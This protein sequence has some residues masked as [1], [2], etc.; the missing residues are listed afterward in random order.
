M[1][2]SRSSKTGAVIAV[3]V[4]L[5]LSVPLLCICGSS[6]DSAASVSTE[7]VSGVD[8]RVFDQNS[9]NYNALVY[10]SDKL[11]TSLSASEWV[12]DA[13][14]GHWYNINSASS[15][16][17]KVLTYG[18]IPG[19]TKSMIKGDILASYHHCFTSNFMLIQVGYTLKYDCNVQLEIVKGNASYTGGSDALSVEASGCYFNK[20]VQKYS[21]CSVKDTGSD[22]DLTVADYRGKY[23][24][25]IGYNGIPVDSVEYTYL[26][27]ALSVKGKVIDAGGEP[28]PGVEIVYSTGTSI[29]YAVTD[30]T[31]VYTIYV[32]RG[33]VV[34]ITNIV[35]SGYTFSSGVG[36]CYG[37]VLNDI[38]PGLTVEANEH[39]IV[40]SVK[41]ASGNNIEGVSLNA[42]WY[43]DDG[44][45]V[46]TDTG[47]ISNRGATGSDGKSYLTVA[48]VSFGNKLYVHGVDGRYTFDTDAMP[49][50][51]SSY[52]IP[53]TLSEGG[54]GYAIEGGSINDLTI[55]AREAMIT[56]TVKGA[57]DSSSQGGAPLPNV[58]VE[59]E[60]YY[61]STDGIDYNI[62]KFNEIEVGYFDNLES[63]KVTFLES[64]TD[65]EG[66]IRLIY[67]APKWAQVAGESA[68][69]YIRSLGAYASSPSSVFH[70]DTAEIEDGSETIT[71]L[72]V[73]HDGCRVFDTGHV[74][75]CELISEEV[76]YTITGTITGDLPESVQ[77]FCI[78]PNNLGDMR[79]ATPV[80]TTMVFTFPVLEG[81]SNRIEIASVNGFEFEK[82][83]QTMPSAHG[84]QSFSCTSVI[85]NTDVTR[86]APSEIATYHV[87]G[88][89]AGDVVTLS[90]TVAGVT[91]SVTVRASSSLIE[92]KVCGRAGNVVESMQVAGEGNVFVGT[93]V[94]NNA[95]AY[96][97]TERSIV[98]YLNDDSND[99]L[100]GNVLSG[101][102]LQV[103]CNGEYYT[104][105]TT[106]S[107]GMAKVSLPSDM[108]L[109]TFKHGEYSVSVS[110][111]TSGAFKDFI[112][113]NFK[114]I[115]E[116]Q[117]PSHGTLT[118]RHIAASSMQNV[119][120]PTSADMMDGP[121]KKVYKIGATE[122]FEAPKM[123]GFSF[124][125]WFIDG[126]SVSDPKDIYTC[127]L[128]LTSEMDGSTLTASYCALDPE[129][130]EEI[131]TI[132]AI[133]MI[134]V[135]IAILALIYVILQIRRY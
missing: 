103:Y 51:G 47:G 5:L 82:Y 113:V 109:L 58:R 129:P 91:M 33:T 101:K 14:D 78:H 54:N 105:V 120:E 122:T 32:D 65:N 61:Q 64:S 127:V 131:G 107:L 22:S 108:S 69:L 66:K 116:P 87:D 99:P 39:T 57:V 52:P 118:I 25:S 2:N 90:Y 81:T 3:I 43:S 45:T 42:I 15:N 72:A 80:S 62:W 55:T 4:S 30:N 40:I 63:G 100:V 29:G 70:F 79:I 110:E 50:N 130:K 67:V 49:N 112:A 76:A 134:S 59:A 111:M 28:I 48:D 133:G 89:E 68:H 132:V 24:I 23:T 36:Y 20:G 13:G 124:S 75:D 102:A 106:D 11:P 71:S 114:G 8:V 38:N 17:S 84:D 128:T 115:V 73:V 83:S 117:G 18:M 98:T 7:G 119:S 44:G 34:T 41:D 9:E 27:S 60:W 104:T 10:L 37:E 16:Y 95:T 92:Y 86:D 6:E 88:M 85:K 56:V 31:G 35:A 135:T 97:I 123:E 121:I 94:G 96:R 12:R 126:R 26:G 93:L 53:E 46:R 125:G 74:V 1:G 21:L 77:A 19:M